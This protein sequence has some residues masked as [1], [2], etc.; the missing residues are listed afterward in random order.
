MKPQKTVNEEYHEQLKK[1]NEALDEKAV[2]QTKQ[3]I[4]EMIEK[5]INK[6]YF[7][8]DRLTGFF[9][10]CFSL[11]REHCDEFKENQRF[12]TFLYKDL[13]TILQVTNHADNLMNWAKFV[14]YYQID[15]DPEVVEY[16]SIKIMKRLTVFSTDEILT[17]IVNM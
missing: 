5:G 9:D 2:D 15:D 16:L 10:K 8:E 1:Q 7:R 17:T 12:R 11:S 13:K 4:L 6:K 14:V 3:A